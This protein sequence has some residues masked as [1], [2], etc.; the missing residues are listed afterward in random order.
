[1][2]LSSHLPRRD[3][4]GWKIDELEWIGHLHSKLSSG[5]LSPEEV[6]EQIKLLNP[7]LT[8]TPPKRIKPVPRFFSCLVA[9]EK[10]FQCNTPPRTIERTNKVILLLQGFVDAAKTGLGSMVEVNHHDINLRIGVWNKE[11]EE[12]SSNWREFENLAEPGPQHAF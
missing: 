11:A 6:A 7:G 1:M 5:K 9:L 3:E 8:V 10:F 4:E 2:N 12:E